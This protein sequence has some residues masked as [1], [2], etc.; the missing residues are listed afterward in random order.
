MIS[1]CFVSVWGFR[2]TE[3]QSGQAS[4]GRGRP[5]R[6]RW[7]ITVRSPRRTPSHTLERRNHHPKPSGSPNAR[8]ASKPECVGTMVLPPLLRARRTPPPI[9]PAATACNWLRFAAPAAAS[10]SREKGS[11]ARVTRKMERGGTGNQETRQVV[12]P[13][14]R[15]YQKSLDGRKVEAI[16]RALS[17]RRGSPFSSMRNG[18]GR[19]RRAIPASGRRPRQRAPRSRR[20]RTS[21]LARPQGKREIDALPSK[22]AAA[23]A[24]AR[25]APRAE[26]FARIERRPERKPRFA[27]PVA[28]LFRRKGTPPEAEHRRRAR[29]PLLDAIEA[30]REARRRNERD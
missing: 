15:R 14:R 26:S 20:E 22:K 8:N 16:L 17:G 13:S 11:F 4:R 19:T 5:S 1:N 12:A 29:R 7:R 24:P 18:G 30:A 21:G 10:R 2:T 25:K 23:R 6:T 3:R 9:K 28:T 27:A